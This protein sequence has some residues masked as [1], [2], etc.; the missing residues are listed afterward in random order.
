[1]RRVLT[2]GDSS[3]NTGGLFVQGWKWRVPPAGHARGVSSRDRCGRW[4]AMR[5][6][7]EFHQRGA[8]MPRALNPARRGH[9]GIDVAQNKPE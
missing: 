5:R 1:M 6:P 9:G 3:D 2:A 7:G 8:L 4:Y